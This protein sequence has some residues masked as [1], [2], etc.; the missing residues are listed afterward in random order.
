MLRTINSKFIAFTIIFIILSVGIPTIFLIN[1]FRENFEQRSKVML[2]T[3]LDTFMFGL[4]NI[5]MQGERK[6]VQHI[7]EKVSLSRGVA[8]IRVLSKSGSILYSTDMME[9]GYKMSVIAPNHIQGSLDQKRIFLLKGE[10]IY[11]A[12]LPIENKPQCQN[13]HDAKSFIAYL[14]IDTD[15]TQAEINFYT[16]SIHIIFL[17]I[18][19]ILVLFFGI[20]FLFNHFIN[21]RLSKFITAFDEVESGNLSVQLPVKNQD[22]FGVL[23]GHFNQMVTKLHS[24]HD[25]IE[26]MHSEQLRR[27]D[28][29]VT[30]GELT[31][32]MAHEINNPAGIIMSRAD[33]LQME[34]QNNEEVQKYT[35]DLNVILDQTEKISK[36]TANILKYGR[37]LPREFGPFDLLHCVE[38]CLNMLEPRLKKKKITLIKHFDQNTCNMVGDPQ[39]IEQVLINLINNAIDAMEELG[40]L[41]VLVGRKSTNDCRL[42]VKDT[43]SGID[44]HSL[45]QIFSPFYTT[46]SPERGTGLGLYIVRN[47]CNNHGATIDCQSSLKE[48]TTFT[49]TFHNNHI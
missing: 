16:G 6:D 19:V 37:K 23:E 25:T 4:E 10:N 8:H 44:E 3:T 46:K 9:I 15:L 41:T 40:E 7:V 32:E 48:G 1:Q 29:L 17:A 22:E 14:D 42:V 18:V 39:Q 12:T 28:K 20:Y 21:K 38:N 2:E 36:I 33:Y 45:Y 5:M 47:I 35:E 24:S 49:I 27:A 31:A 43:G 30:L 26:E 13:C 11:S 34:S